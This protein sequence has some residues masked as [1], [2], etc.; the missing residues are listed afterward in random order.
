MN[1]AT[2]RTATV[3]L[4]WINRH[5]ACPAKSQTA[6]K[7]T[8]R[9]TMRGRAGCIHITYAPTM[10]S[11][12]GQGLSTQ[13]SLTHQALTRRARFAL[14]L[15]TDLPET[16]QRTSWQVTRSFDDLDIKQ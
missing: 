6:G 2:G 5:D 8:S 13:A 9:A 7:L 15:R 16:F 10:Q 3:V 1:L 14:R 11:H 4:H 12:S